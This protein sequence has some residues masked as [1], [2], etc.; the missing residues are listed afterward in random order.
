MVDYFVFD[1]VNTYE[2]YGVILTDANYFDSATRS[3]TTEQVPGRNG[4]LI[5]DGGRFENSDIELTGLIKNNFSSQFPLL[6]D[7]LESSPGYKKLEISKE[8][9]EFFL[10]RIS[11]AL[12]P[13]TSLKQKTG[14]FS[15][16]FSRKPQRFL[17]S[18]E[19]LTQITSGTVLT[20]PTNQTSLPLINC[21]GSGT[22]TLGSQSLKITGNPYDYI[23]VDSDIK[24]C[25]FKNRN[26]NGYITADSFP[27]L[28][29]GDT[30]VTFTGFTKIEIAPRWWRL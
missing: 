8:P 16:K 12:E 25:F 23:T 26:C 6:R 9:D 3:V 20:N 29:A 1:E 27:E 7:W 19:A 18:G 28:G 11:N 24:D 2:K 22:L 17:K 13:E 4:E 15:I 14:W 5:F 21:Y 10:A 30:K